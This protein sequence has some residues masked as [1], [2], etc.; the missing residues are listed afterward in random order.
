MVRGSM[1]APLHCLSI[2]ELLAG[3]LGNT[4]LM[5]LILQQI[6]LH[7]FARP[8]AEDA[9]HQEGEIY[10]QFIVNI[11]RTSLFRDTQV[12]WCICRGQSTTCGSQFSP[13]CGS[14]RSNSSCQAWRQRQVPLPAE[15]Y[16]GPCI[17]LLRYQNKAEEKTQLQAGWW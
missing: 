2:T 16:I 13:C 9:G 11:L 17:G 14:W 10:A 4:G 6:I 12:S 3:A 8:M 1:M 5:S 15:A 7:S